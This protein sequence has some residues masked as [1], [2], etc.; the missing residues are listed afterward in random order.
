M[1]RD[2]ET[3]YTFVSGDIESLADQLH[4]TATMRDHVLEQLGR[5]G[6]RWVEESFS[7]ER[8]R[9]RMT[10]LYRALGVC[11]RSD[12]RSVRSRDATAKHQRH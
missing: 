10:A 8:Y 12:D 2:G 11:N 9:E 3:G 1:I 4:A 5:E 7:I 6:R